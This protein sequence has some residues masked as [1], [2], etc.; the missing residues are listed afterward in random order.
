MCLMLEHACGT[1]IGV[2]QA[3]L[4]LQGQA[5]GCVQHQQPRPRQKTKPPKKKKSTFRST[6]QS[7]TLVLL[8]ARGNKR[9]WTVTPQMSRK[10]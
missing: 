5:P 7:P 3:K 4:A 6:L 2:L 9:H 8:A 1:T 10:R